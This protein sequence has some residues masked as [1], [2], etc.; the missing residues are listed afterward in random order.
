MQSNLGTSSSNW[1][2]ILAAAL[3]AFGV[4][5]V[6]LLI[7]LLVYDDW[8]HRTGPLHVIGASI[9][10]LL[11]FVFVVRWQLAVREKQREMIARFERIAQMNDRIRNAL[12]AI[13]FA[14]YAARSPAA[15]PVRDAVES[16]DKVLTEVLRDTHFRQ[17]PSGVKNPL[18]PPLSKVT[19]ASRF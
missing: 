8:L 12:Q 14:T 11:T 5:T 1:K 2:M 15:E 13:E 18:A 4:L 7:Q 3:C 10:A 19:G 6:S 16:I 9:A 17:P